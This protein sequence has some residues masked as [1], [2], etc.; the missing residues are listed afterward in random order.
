MFSL[1]RVVFQV[2]RKTDL[3]CRRPGLLQR[4]LFSNGTAK[5]RKGDGVK[6]GL[7][8]VRLLNFLNAIVR[9]SMRFV[10]TEF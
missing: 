7:F 4:S 3:L 1:S 6:K 5:A 9:Y 8:P 10:R 2:G